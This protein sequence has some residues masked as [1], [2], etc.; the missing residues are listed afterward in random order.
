MIAKVVVTPVQKVVRVTPP[1]RTKL[2][3]APREPSLRVVTGPTKTVRVSHAGIPGPA[4]SRVLEWTPYADGSIELNRR[5][6]RYRPTDNITFRPAD[7][8]AVLDN[9]TVAQSVWLLKDAAGATI[10]QVTFGAG[11][12][13]GTVTMTKTAFIRGDVID[14]FTPAAVNPAENVFSLTLPADR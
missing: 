9:A 5:I 12:T 3:L 6:A 14:L 11:Q 7:A 10:G 2:I 13:V 8:I 4:G 1:S